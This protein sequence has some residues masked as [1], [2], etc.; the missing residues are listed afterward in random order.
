MTEVHSSPVTI[1]CELF[2]SVISV[3]TNLRFISESLAHLQDKESVVLP[4]TQL[5]SAVIVALFKAA[6]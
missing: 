6:A 2:D 1:S 3:L 5:A 4:H